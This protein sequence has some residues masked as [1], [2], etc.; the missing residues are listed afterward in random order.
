MAV[1]A[2]SFLA[3]GEE[4]PTFTGALLLMFGVVV[5]PMRF[6]LGLRIMEETALP[7]LQRGKPG[8]N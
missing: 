6:F 7:S 5:L 2:V 3:L 1:W 8:A 4:L